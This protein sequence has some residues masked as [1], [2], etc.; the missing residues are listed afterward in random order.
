MGVQYTI[1]TY[2]N[3]QQIL[4]FDEGQLYYMTPDTQYLS[5]K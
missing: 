2:N 4:V 3:R 1:F 5:F